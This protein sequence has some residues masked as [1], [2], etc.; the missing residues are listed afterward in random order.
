LRFF[1]IGVTVQAMPEQAWQQF[2]YDTYMDGQLRARLGARLKGLRVERGL[3]QAQLAERAQ[4]SVGTLQGIEG[5]HRN[6]RRRI[7]DRVAQALG[8]SVQQ[9]VR[10]GV[11]R[12]LDTPALNPED[13]QIAWAF[14]HAATPTRAQ[15]RALLLPADTQD[16][17]SPEPARARKSRRRA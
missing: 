2:A 10:E 11:A 5:G 6:T 7:L 3:H 14:H 15:A 4:I 1:V 9:I 13:L 17:S 8:T 16:L 12:G